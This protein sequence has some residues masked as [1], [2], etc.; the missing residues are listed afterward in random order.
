M[1]L[2]FDFSIPTHLVQNPVSFQHHGIYQNVMN[3]QMNRLPMLHVLDFT[4]FKDSK[5]YFHAFMPYFTAG[6]V[7][8]GE[9]VPSL[10]TG[11]GKL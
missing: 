7:T 5:L 4:K 1:G 8:A 6:Y 3:W 2:S 10:T 9:E 11:M